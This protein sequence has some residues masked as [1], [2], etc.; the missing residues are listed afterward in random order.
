MSCAITSSPTVWSEFFR[1]IA[2]FRPATE[3]W[4]S[5]AEKRR[6]K[7]RGLD[8]SSDMETLSITEHVTWLLTPFPVVSDWFPGLACLGTS[9]NQPDLGPRL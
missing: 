3:Y 7:R 9:Q 4:N 1:R 8:I 5:E 6:V 2:L